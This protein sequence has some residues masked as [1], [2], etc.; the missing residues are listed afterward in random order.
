MSERGSVWAAMVTLV[1]CLPLFLILAHAMT[2]PVYQSNYSARYS[3]YQ[4]GE[5]TRRQAE[6]Q[7][8]RVQAEQFGDTLRTWGMWG[9]GVL[10]VALVAGAGSYTVVQWQRERTRRHSMTEQRRIALAWIAANGGQQRLADGSTRYRIGIYPTGAGREYGVLDAAAG[11][12]VPLRVAAAELP[13][14]ALLTVDA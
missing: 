9:G 1:V 2:S 4:A 13:A 11:E 3:A 5:T 12:F 6:E 7:T 14:A 8:R 10:S